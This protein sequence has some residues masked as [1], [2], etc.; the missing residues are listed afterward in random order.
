MTATIS[1][2]TPPTLRR[3]DLSTRLKFWDLYE[4]VVF[5]EDNRLEIA[6]EFFP[7]AP[8]FATPNL[9]WVALKTVLQ[10]GVPERERARIIVESLAGDD[11]P[12]RKYLDLATDHHALL[13]EIAEQRAAHL[14]AQR[15]AGRITNW[16]F[17]LTC[18]LSN[19]KKRTRGLGFSPDELRLVLDEAHGL[20]RRLV[21]SL[22]NAGLEPRALEDQEVFDLMWRYLNPGLVPA[23]PPRFKPFNERA[24]YLNDTE[25]RAHPIHHATLTRQVANSS[26]DN[27]DPNFLI[28]GDRFVKSISFCNV[29]TETHAGCLR[30]LMQDTSRT[31]QAFHLIIDYRHEPQGPKLRKLEGQVRR[32]FAAANATNMPPNPQAEVALEETREV[33]QNLTRSGDHVYTCA[34]TAVMSARSLN[35]LEA[36]KT[37]VTS[38]FSAYP[39]SLPVNGPYQTLASYFSCVPMGGG[40]G[41]FLFETVESNAADLVP[42]VAPWKGHDR[43]VMLLKSR[44]GSFLGIDTFDPSL[45]NYNGFIAARS[46]HGKTFLNQTH[47][48]SLRRIGAEIFIVDQKQDYGPLVEAFGGKTIAFAPDSGVAINIFDL[49]RGD[50]TPSDTKRDLLYTVLRQMIGPSPDARD[51]PIEKAILMDNIPKVYA[52]ARPGEPVTLSDYRRAL[53]TTQELGG[54]RMEDDDRRIARSLA[55]RLHPWTRDFPLGK[56]FDTPSNVSLEDDI[57]YFDI[58]SIQ[59]DA[60]L[61][62]VAMLLISDIIWRRAMRDRRRPSM[63]LLEEFWGML[64]T[65][66]ARELAEKLFRLARTYNL[67]AW[68][69]SQSIKD[70]QAIPALLNCTTFFYIGKL[71]NEEATTTLP[72][73]LKLGPSVLAEYESLTQ[74]RGEYSEWLLI[75]ETQAGRV[76][77]VV[78]IEPNPFEYW[79]Y[80]TEGPEIARRNAAKA[81][82]GSVVKAVRALVEENADG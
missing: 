56:M 49:E 12:I 35:A 2:L 44:W 10:Q 16:R 33:L 51:A 3:G 27:S 78:R 40:I 6:I 82:H 17:F 36:A 24:G 72:N 28:V 70:A 79:L 9:N 43:P 26:V 45:T 15:R 4:G 69:T 65:P 18:T 61:T 59:N 46:G 42:P 52:R 73:T 62:G 32:Y 34:I 41:E 74:R 58:S 29:P 67:A 60:E 5:L 37:E 50:T 8:L 38:A 53:L 54:A 39:G 66:E 21:S 30:R 20:R 80:T 64:R 19:F 13:E 31:G 48:A 11:A 14:E 23:T 75:V 47:I 76:G 57:L 22:S 71:V 7:P 77:D 1:N 68:A 63:A 25:L 55:T 81:R